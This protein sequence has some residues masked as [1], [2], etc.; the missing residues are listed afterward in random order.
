MSS[1]EKSEKRVKSEKGE[2]GEKTEKGEKA[3]KREGDPIGTV[4]GG[5]V[6]IVLG[7]AFYLVVSGRIDW[8]QWWAYFIAG[9]GAVLL[10]DALMRAALPEY[11]RFIIGR[12]VGGVILLGLGALNILEIE[13]VWPLVLVGGGVAVILYGVYT[14]RRRGSSWTES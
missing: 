2:K 1:A 14:S 8:T 6:L 4:F 12:V 11:R 9:L 5:L 7:I 3:E 13:D 10:L